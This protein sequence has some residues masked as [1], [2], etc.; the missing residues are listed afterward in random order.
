MK[1]EFFR[2]AE[3]IA[4]F[5]FWE[6]RLDKKMFEV[7]AN[8]R[9]IYGV[10]PNT[11]LIMNDI[12]QIPL[13]EFRPML[14]QALS[15]LIS[16][17]KP[18]NVEFK[19]RRPC[20]QK[21]AVIHSEAEYDPRTRSV[22]GVISDITHRHQA[23]EEI[24][25]SEEKYR[26]LFNSISDAIY[27]HEVGDD[28][29]GRFVEV[30]DGACKLMGYTREEF[31]QLSPKVL[32][33]PNELTDAEVVQQKLH[34]DGHVVFERIHVTKDGRRIPVEIS[35]QTVTQDGRT[36]YLSVVRDITERKTM[37]SRLLQAAEQWRAT[38]DAITTPVSIQDKNYRILRVN[39][40]FAQAMKMTPGELIGKTC[41]E[42]SHGTSEPVN[43]CPH[44]KTMETGQAIEVEIHNAERGT[45]SL[46]STYPMFDPDGDIIASVHITQDVT[47]R[48]RMQEQLMVTNRL[49]SV[50]ELAAGVAHEIN[51]PLTGILG[52]SELL[53]ESALPDNIRKDVEIIHSEARRSA[54]IIKNLLV[55]ARR[56]NPAKELLNVNEIIQRVLALR[57]YDT[58]LNNIDVIPHLDP[59]LPEITADAFQLQ[60]VFLNIVINAEFFMLK[61][62]QRGTLTITT[63]YDKK[64]DRVRIVI[65]D[66]GPGIAPEN[67]DRLFDPFFTTKEVDQGTGLGLSISHG[68]I[69][70]HGGAIRA[71][72]QSGGGA[73]FIIELPRLAPAADRPE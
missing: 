40:A 36:L 34:H 42:V 4:G 39:Q 14:D 12:Q 41:Y 37:E 60:Q 23:E 8:A 15:E 2:R 35:S 31:L 29:R 16:E 21:I 3:Q 49:A 55:F 33:D 64:N 67:L 66:D 32:D 61:A 46:V 73:A 53:L 22:L 68:V 28:G 27:F 58:K 20:D 57:A 59:D 72:N 11:P 52:F 18:Y 48:R 19:I 1:Q 45:Y 5:G 44:R 38:F 71:E 56:H 6:L 62:H 13:P 43:I 7:S 25:R 9:R 54:E 30:N 70:Q 51:N 65:T 24:R 17:Q 10:S 50:G 63:G 47:E 69:K 26:L